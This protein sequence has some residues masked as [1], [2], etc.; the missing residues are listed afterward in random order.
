MVAGEQD[1]FFP[2]GVAEVIGSVA[3]CIDALRG[4][5]IAFDDVAVV[6]V[7]VRFEIHVAALFH[8]H[9]GGDLADAVA[10][11]AVGLRIGMCSQQTAARRVI[12]VGMGNQ[13]MR[14]CFA[15][16]GAKDRV[17]VGGV[18]RPGSITATL[19]WPRM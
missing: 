1:V 8:L 17:D 6:D 15:S 10:T 16:G 5:A 13:H 4:P 12:H 19:P 7:N 18:S 11:K 2:Q 14:D 9:A 3:G